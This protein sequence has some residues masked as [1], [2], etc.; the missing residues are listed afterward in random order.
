M[1]KEHDCNNLERTDH[2]SLA[3]ENKEKHFQIN[4]IKEKKE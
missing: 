4:I 3:M 2:R 1:R